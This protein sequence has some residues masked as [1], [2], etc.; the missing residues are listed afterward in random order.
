VEYRFLFP[1]R[2][3]LR[4]KWQNREFE[5]PRDPSIFNNIETRFRLEYRLSRYDR[6]TF[7]YAVSYTQWPPR[8]RLQGEATATGNNPIVGNNAQPASAWGAAI[9]HNFKNERI[10]LD[11]AFVVYDGFLWFFEKSTFRIA[12]GRAFRAWFEI[13]D[14]LSDD[15]TVR[16]RYV[17][18]N[19]LRNTAV[20]IRQ[21]N[22]EVG[23][24][25]DADNVKP[26]RDYFRLQ[27]D[28]AF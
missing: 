14:R 9:T 21:F 17:R 13:T 4:H 26:T 20:D 22:E 7:D 10:K 23:Q 3:K 16:L 15:L 2:F 28:Y 5:N 18:E 19:G 1:L 24:E 25:I 11:G 8:G 27:M 6:L 12:D